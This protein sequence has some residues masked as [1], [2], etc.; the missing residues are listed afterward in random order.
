M[1]ETQAGASGPRVNPVSLARI[2]PRGVLGIGMG[3]RAPVSEPDRRRFLA[4]VFSSGTSMKPR[5]RF[6]SPP[7]ASVAAESARASRGHTRGSRERLLLGAAWKPPA[8]C[9]TAYGLLDRYRGLSQYDCSTR[10]VFA[11]RQ[12]TVQPLR[13]D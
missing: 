3:K 6:A 10:R 7:L 1:Q 11:T 8:D 9:H 4:S 5:V 2:I 12:A 13:R